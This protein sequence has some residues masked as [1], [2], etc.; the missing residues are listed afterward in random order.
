MAEYDNDKSLYRGN[1]M[2][3][4][5]AAAVGAA[6]ALLALAAV[7]SAAVLTGLE[8][9]IPAELRPLVALYSDVEVEAGKTFDVT[10]LFGSL[11]QPVDPWEVVEG[12]D[13][14]EALVDAHDEAME[15]RM[16]NRAAP[17]RPLRD[18]DP[19]AATE[20][21][22]TNPSTKLSKKQRAKLMR[23]EGA[24]IAEKRRAYRD[25]V[26]KVA[27]AGAKNYGMVNEQ[28]D[29]PI[30][31]SVGE[32]VTEP[33]TKA[34]AEPQPSIALLVIAPF[35]A[36][37]SAEWLPAE[38]GDVRLTMVI[39]DLPYRDPSEGWK[40]AL[41][42]RCEHALVH[43]GDDGD[44]DEDDRAAVLLEAGLRKAAEEHGSHN[45]VA[46]AGASKPRA[47]GLIRPLFGRAANLASNPEV[48]H[49]R[50]GILATARASVPQAV[51]VEAAA[52]TIGTSLDRPKGADGAGV[53]GG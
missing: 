42:G 35:G 32:Y 50:N 9:Y 10:S 53:L 38:R 13:P 39:E 40:R 37:A 43:S 48:L 7:T 49:C 19:D 44:A 23:R 27:L 29:Q 46:T 12:E 5:K 51:L 14:D 33:C 31:K 2:G 34:N 45:P 30:E 20:A 16:R 18:D 11:V 21:T 4:L 47:G 28:T 8:E 6:C 52:G 26:T 17:S 22:T 15:M 25:L 3:R 1:A 41:G 24:K 36:N